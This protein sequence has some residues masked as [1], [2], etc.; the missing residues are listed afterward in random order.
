M[1]LLGT[2]PEDML[3]V[4]QHVYDPARTGMIPGVN[5][6]HNSVASRLLGFRASVP[7]LQRM[8]RV[9]EHYELVAFFALRGP[10]RIAPRIFASGDNLPLAT[11]LITLH[12]RSPREVFESAATMTISNI[13]VATPR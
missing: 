13:L 6:P 12:S 9:V 4:W 7:Q 1:Q 8:V 10:S 11:M 5:T 3:D 2:T